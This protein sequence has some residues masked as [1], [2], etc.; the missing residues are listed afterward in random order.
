VTEMLK[1]VDYLGYDFAGRSGVG[2]K[3]GADNCDVHVL[4][5]SSA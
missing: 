2:G 4:I 5:A 3:M 1:L